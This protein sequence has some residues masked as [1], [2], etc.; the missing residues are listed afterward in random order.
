MT[1]FIRQGDLLIKSVESI[2]ELKKKKDTV[3]LEGGA[4]NHFHRLQGGTVYEESPTKENNWSIGYFELTEDTDLTH[5]EHETIRIK[6]GKYRF[7]HQ[8]EYD[9]QGDRKVID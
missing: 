9:P 8:R 7:F 4:S 1:Q 6:K 2:P 3:L 5:E